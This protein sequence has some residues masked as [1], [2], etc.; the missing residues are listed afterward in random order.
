MLALATKIRKKLIGKEGNKKLNEIIE[1]KNYKIKMDGI[2]LY[3]EAEERI[4]H[5][6]LYELK[7]LD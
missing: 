4:V 6:K 1:E 2:V 3:L 7:S 5:T